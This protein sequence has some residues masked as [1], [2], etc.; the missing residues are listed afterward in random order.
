MTG[1]NYRPSGMD[2]HALLDALYSALHERDE[3]RRAC[4]DYK[5]FVE[6]KSSGLNAIDKRMLEEGRKR[7]WED[8]WSTLCG[9]TTR[10]YLGEPMSVGEYGKR[11]ALHIPSWMSE[12]EF[13]RYYATEIQSEYDKALAAEREV[14]DADE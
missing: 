4:D 1:I 14:E 11:H 9:N 5:R 12:D 2:T 10:D 8:T 6:S 13:I 7:V 3:L